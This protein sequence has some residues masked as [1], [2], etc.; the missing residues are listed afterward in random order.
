MSNKRQPLL[1][2]PG[3]GLEWEIW[4][5]PAGC[6]QRTAD[7]SAAVQQA[8][9]VVVA[10]PVPHCLIFAAWLPTADP[11]LLPEMVF[12]QIERRGLAPR[13][14]EATVFDHAVVAQEAG[15]SLVR[16][17]ILTSDFPAE[18][19][20]PN[21]RGFLPSPVFLPLPEDGMVIWQER[22]ILAL[23]ATRGSELVHAQVLS[24]GDQLVPE[25]VGDIQAIR[26]ALQFEQIVREITSV[27]VWGEFPNATEALAGLKLPVHSL[28]RPEPTLVKTARPGLLPIP[29]RA[30]RQ[31]RAAKNRTLRNALA[32]VAVYLALVV[33]L[34]GY[35][36]TLRA[37]R[38]GL[39]EAIG[40]DGPVATELG[41]TAARWRAI[42]PAVNPKLYAIEQ[43][44]QCSSALP[45]AG[46]RFT[47]F[48]TIGTDI[49]I[50]GIARNAPTLY[51]YVDELKRNPE[52]AA[53]QWKMGQPKL[54]KDDSAEFKLEGTYG[55]AK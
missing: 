2:F 28:P 36:N 18:L 4:S 10:V 45:P 26:M 44:Y 41:R 8:G 40:N 29:L 23:A 30:A 13:G 21:G 9:S 20:F 19:C 46:V 38:N 39:A 5:G 24:R 50:K 1:V 17:E 34:W 55:K 25:M 47:A 11:A 53:Y 52:L 6:E 48:E 16:I 37:K 33:V 35:L 14:R 15:R 31:V 43:F 32:G 27:T 12:A 49:R 54:Q 51:R 7:P 42:E 3:P 22:G